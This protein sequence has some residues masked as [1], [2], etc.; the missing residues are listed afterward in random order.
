MRLNYFVSAVCIAALA[1]GPAFAAETAMTPGMMAPNMMMATTPDGH[2]GSMMMT[3]D[4]MTSKMMGMATPVTG[5]MMMMTD[6][7]GKM[8]MVDTSSADAMAECNKLAMTP[9]AMPADDNMATPAM[10]APNM[11]MAM[12]PDGH[13]GSMMVTDPAMA[14][15]MMG[16]AK[17]APGCMMMMSDKD[18]KMSMIDTS[19]ADAMAECNKLA[20][21]PPA[22]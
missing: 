10:M 8:S 12:M 7:D 6:K 11:A 13:M 14:D 9:A 18:G 15:T 19:S 5:C 20:M 1:I 4:A 2:M 16:M 21:T 3:D 17:P 22:M